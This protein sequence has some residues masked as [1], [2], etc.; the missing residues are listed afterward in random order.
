M[1]LASDPHAVEPDAKYPIAG[2]Y[3]FGRGMIQRA[4][5]TGRE[6]AASQL[7]R[8][9]AGQLIY[10][11]LK[12]FEGAYA[13]V[14]DEVD[15]YFVSNEFPTFDLH[16]ERVE[17]SFLR[18]YL[19]QERIWRQLASD[20]KGI[21]AR[22]ERLHPKRFLEHEIALP[23]LPEQ[24]RVAG[25]LDNIAARIA[26]RRSK[27]GVAEIELSAALRAAFDKI[28]TGAPRRRLGDVA[29]I[30]RRPVEIEANGIYSELGV[31]S[32][33]RGLF[34]KPDLRGVELTWQKLF[35]IRR[36]DLVF[37]NIK[38]WEGAFAVA[39]P[40]DDGKVGSHRYLTCVVDNMI[41]SPIFLCYFLQSPSGLS[42]V[43]AASPGSADR[44]R[45]L[46]QKKLAAIDVPVPSIEDQS[47]F[48]DLLRRV[49]VARAKLSDVGAE[50]DHLIPSLMHQAFD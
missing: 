50:L 43:Q 2:V 32:F 18:W 42:Q 40:D 15:G 38:A 5:V 33:G 6:I 4:A 28:V 49:E 7:F 35:Q 14:S 10:S 13:I 21:G 19:K 44:N 24:Q 41:A 22:R 30:V 16:T 3:G 26:W 8:I 11:R 45:T 12:S 37:S 47:W 31:R 34:K 27:A 1:E 25:S 36:G 29:P 20:G 39:G 46:S 9:R 48:D 17:P 23:P